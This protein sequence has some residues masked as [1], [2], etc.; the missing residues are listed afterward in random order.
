MRNLI[1]LLSLILS[2]NINAQSNIGEIDPG[3]EQQKLADRMWYTACS[4]GSVRIM[5]INEEYRSFADYCYLTLSKK[6]IKVFIKQLKAINNKSSGERFMF[7]NDKYR[8]HGSKGIF[9]RPILST[10]DGWHALS[11]F[12]RNKIIRK[13]SI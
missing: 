7:V 1:M 11:K 5:F 6:D 10:D 3:A 12:K 8:L 2:I 9:S 4:D 13:L